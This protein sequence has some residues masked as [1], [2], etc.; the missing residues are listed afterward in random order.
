M[1]QLITSSAYLAGVG[2]QRGSFLNNNNNNNNNTNNNNNNNNIII[3]N[4]KY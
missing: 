3:I 2:Q 4:V 1:L